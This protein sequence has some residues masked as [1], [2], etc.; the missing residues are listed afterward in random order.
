MKALLTVIIAI[1]LHSSLFSQ[2]FFINFKNVEIDMKVDTNFMDDGIL[3]RKLYASKPKSGTVCDPNSLVLIGDFVQDSK[4][5][6]ILNYYEYNYFW[7]PFNP[8]IPFFPLNKRIPKDIKSGLLI[9]GAHSS[10]ERGAGDITY[11][12]SCGE[13]TPQTTNS[14]GCV[15]RLSHRLISC[16]NEGPCQTGCLGTVIEDSEERIVEGGG[17]LIQVSKAKANLIHNFGTRD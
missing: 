11:W 16:I 8:K 3:I 12:C 10:V 7:A 1:V 15:S 4:K 6:I 5:N 14:G 13:T 9:I 17:L 2:N